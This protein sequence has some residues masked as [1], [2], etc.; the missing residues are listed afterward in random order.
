M[1]A[2]RLSPEGRRSLD[3]LGLAG[4]A[5]APAPG[6]LVART[7][8]S[9]LSCQCPVLEAWPGRVGCGQG[10]PCIPF[11]SARIPRLLSNR[12]ALA[13][14][15]APTGA[16]RLPGGPGV[17]A[18]HPPA[19]GGGLGGGRGAGAAKRQA[20]KLPAGGQAGRELAS[21]ACLSVGLS[22]PGLVPGWPGGLPALGPRRPD[23]PRGAAGPG[24]AGRRGCCAPPGQEFGG[25]GRQKREKRRESVS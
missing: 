20:A 25:Q 15:P 19:P 1:R 5:P 23:R 4:Q 17:N 6:P 18:P 24:A 12:P 21:P 10:L 13:Q 2:L 16:A 14:P 8:R 11:L 9:T 7:G 3:Q 22:A